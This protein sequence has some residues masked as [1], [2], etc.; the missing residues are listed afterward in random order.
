MSYE[1]TGALY[2]GG[3]AVKPLVEG[4]QRHPGKMAAPAIVIEG[5]FVLDARSASGIKITVPY[6][7]VQTNSIAKSQ[8]TFA[9]NAIYRLSTGK[10][11]QIAASQPG[12]YGLTGFQPTLPVVVSR[13]GVKWGGYT[14]AFLP[15]DTARPHRDPL[16]FAIPNKW[17]VWKRLIDGSKP[18][19]KFQ[20]PRDKRTWGIFLRIHD[21]VFTFKFKRVTKSWLGKLWTWVKDV[22]A[23][24]IELVKDLYDFLKVMACPLAKMYLL[25]LK[26]VSEGD[27][28][29]TEKM[30]ITAATGV[31]PQALDK[32]A[33]DPTVDAAMNLANAVNETLCP[34]A[35]GAT[36]SASAS[37]ISSTTWL[38]FGLAGAA[39][40]Y[41]L[42]IKK[43]R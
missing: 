8:V 35:E 7:K 15:L 34:R 33:A 40:I 41:F 39:A 17:V 20:H 24:L 2:S 30:A 29:P 6:T 9:M 37:G 21:G 28:S 12:G 42:V 26:K 18:F 32:L 5:G 27:A 1:S 23:R 11:N 43:G 16:G 31:P 25:K 22:V 36:S 3:R 4:M 14:K 38:L 13:G 10:A 19:V